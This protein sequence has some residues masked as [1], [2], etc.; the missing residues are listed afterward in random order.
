MSTEN[1]VQTKMEHQESLSVN[2]V[3]VKVVGID[4]VQIEPY[5]RQHLMSWILSH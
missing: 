5:G 4:N 3:I 1:S 2:L